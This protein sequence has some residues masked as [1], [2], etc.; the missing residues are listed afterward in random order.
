M[1]NMPINILKD[2]SLSLS[3]GKLGFF[4]FFP[5][6]KKREKIDLYMY[7]RGCNLLFYVS[8]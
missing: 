8:S 7:L 5:F 2:L 3:F 6:S 1:E 4:F